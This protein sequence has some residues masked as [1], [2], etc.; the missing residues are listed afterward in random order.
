MKKI[1]LIWIV[2]V[3]LVIC[4]RADSARYISVRT[5]LVATVT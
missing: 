2:A 1:L 5:C 4:M 3:N